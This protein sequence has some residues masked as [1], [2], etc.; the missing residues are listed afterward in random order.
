MN[1]IVEYTYTPRC[2][3]AVGYAHDNITDYWAD[4]EEFSGKRAEEIIVAI[5][6]GETWS[7]I[8]LPEEWEILHT[9]EE[10]DDR[11]DITAFVTAY[12]QDDE[13]AEPIA[14]TSRVIDIHESEG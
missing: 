11:G 10:A 12:D 2:R 9:D 14:R 1:I 3:A 5:K 13:D 8:E 7:D 4:M 6:S